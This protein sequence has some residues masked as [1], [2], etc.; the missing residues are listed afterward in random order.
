[1]VDQSARRGVNTHTP[2]TEIAAARTGG[3]FEE[4]RHSFW[5]LG[6]HAD[7]GGMHADLYD[8]AGLERDAQCCRDCLVHAIRLLKALRNES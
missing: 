8:L 2:T 5:S 4:L 1:M 6:V 3:L 7:V